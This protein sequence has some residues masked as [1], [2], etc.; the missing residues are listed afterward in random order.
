[1]NSFAADDNNNVAK[2]ADQFVNG[3]FNQF[4]DSSSYGDDRSK[5]PEWER[6]HSPPGWAEGPKG[7]DGDNRYHRSPPENNGGGNGRNGGNNGGGN[8]QNGGNNGGGN[9]Q[10]GGDD[11]SR[12]GVRARRPIISSLCLLPSTAECKG[13]TSALE[14]AEAHSKLSWQTLLALYSEGM[15]PKLL[16]LADAQATIERETGRGPSSLQDS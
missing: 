13:L 6:S 10:S 16:R 14:A 15:H 12:Q 5:S 11:R 3:L 4:Q 2:N 7:D 8:G 9:S 1:V